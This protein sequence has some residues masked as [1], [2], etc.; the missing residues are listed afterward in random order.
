MDTGKSLDKLAEEI[1][2]S[3]KDIELPAN[4]S[5]TVTGEE[6]KRRESMNSLLFALALSVILV[7]HG[8]GIAVRI[9]FASVHDPVDHPLGGSR[10]YPAVFPDRDDDQY[11]GCDRYR[12]AGRYCRE[13]LDHPGG[14]YQPAE[15]GSR[16]D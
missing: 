8:A 1:R 7:Y 13:Q 10:R 6:E 9:A 15:D 3:V 5:I 2:R 12:D 4:Y 14:P 16:P 11:D